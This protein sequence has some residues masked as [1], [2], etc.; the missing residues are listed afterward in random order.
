MTGVIFAVFMTGMAI[1]SFYRLHFYKNSTFRGFLT[2]Q[3]IFAGFSALLAGLMLL[4]PSN[5]IHWMIILLILILV[6]ISGLLMGIQFS[7]SGQLR[8]T[9]ILQSSGESFSAD[10]LGSAIGIGLVAV[11]LIPQF[12]L[13]MTGM[14]LAGLNIVAIGVIYVKGS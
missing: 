11:Y 1:G 4:I 12:G 13:P 2:I 3:G 14:V 7:L 5:S 8:K 9:S 10:L 6:F